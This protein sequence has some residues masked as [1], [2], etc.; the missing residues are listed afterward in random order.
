VAGCP[1]LEEIHGAARLDL[2]TFARGGGSG[3]VGRRAPQNAPRTL[4][5]SALMAWRARTLAERA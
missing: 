4:S 1:L 2:D 5:S 3:R